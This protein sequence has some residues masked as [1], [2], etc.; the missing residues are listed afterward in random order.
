M[1]RKILAIA[2]LLA[3][4]AAVVAVALAQTSAQNGQST[5]G[6]QQGALQGGLNYADSTLVVPGVDAERHLIIL[7]AGS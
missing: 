1:S 4:P 2:A 3:L 5:R 6:V 7:K